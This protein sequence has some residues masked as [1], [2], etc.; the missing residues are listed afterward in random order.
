MR[1]AMANRRLLY[2]GGGV[3]LAMAA[4]GYSMIGMGDKS[5]KSSD[6]AQV[7]SDHAEVASAGP[8]AHP[9]PTT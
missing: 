6:H 1:F 9:T 5:D 3:L 8:K 2:L 7:S 4:A